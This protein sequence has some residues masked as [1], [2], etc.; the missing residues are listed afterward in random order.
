MLRRLIFIPLFVL[1]LPGAFFG[2]L[3]ALNAFNPIALAFKTDFSVTN[4][5]SERMHVTPVGAVG[6]DGERHRLPLL[7]NT[8]G[9]WFLPNNAN[10][11]IEP[12]QTRQFVYDWDDI[13]F[14]ELLLEAGGQRYVLVVD[15]Q[16][17]VN[18][19][20]RPAETSFNVGEPTTL[21]PA[22]AHI[23]A[24]ADPQVLWRRTYVAVSTTVV[25]GYMFAKA[26]KRRGHLRR[27]ARPT[28]GGNVGA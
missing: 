10:L 2:C 4:Q 12:G 3:L 20:R 19:Y 22:P 5:S 6:P 26:W 13:Q 17:T 16:P 25:L 14:S 28:S 7:A 11:V 18:Q 23:A 9:Y 24:L 21:A 8:A 27:N 1:C 15:S